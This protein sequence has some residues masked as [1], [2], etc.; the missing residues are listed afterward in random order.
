[1]ETQVE[2]EDGKSLVCQSVMQTDMQTVRHAHTFCCKNVNAAMW[3]VARYALQLV[4]F[5][6]LWQLILHLSRCLKS[7]WPS[8]AINLPPLSV[9]WQSL[10]TSAIAG[11]VTWKFCLLPLAASPVSS[12]T[13]TMEKEDQCCIPSEREDA[14]LIQL[15]HVLAASCGGKRLIGNSRGSLSGLIKRL[16]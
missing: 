14:A 12:C 13:R 2:L 1:M 5:W 16:G 10:C 8:L 15:L 4:F 7:T 11:N 3:A 9:C 6:W